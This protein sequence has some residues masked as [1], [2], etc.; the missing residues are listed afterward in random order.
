LPTRQEDPT[1][2]RALL[3]EDSRDLA[4]KKKIKENKVVAAFELPSRRDEA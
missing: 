1:P 4:K 3:K 2:S